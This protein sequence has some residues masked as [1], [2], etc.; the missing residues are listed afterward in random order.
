MIAGYSQAGYCEECK[1]L[2]RE[3][4]RLGKFRPVG[5]AVV[6]V[7]QACL[8]SNDLMLGMEVHQ[9]VNENQIEMDVLLCN[10]FIGLYAKM[11]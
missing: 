4:L 9:F 3:M 1:E 5:L 2:Y 7:L 6:S 8:Q 11:W 10:A